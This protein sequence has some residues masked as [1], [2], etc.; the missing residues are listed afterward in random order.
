MW[1]GSFLRVEGWGYEGSAKQCCKNSNSSLL[2]RGGV[3]K[4]LYEMQE[5]PRLGGLGKEKCCYSYNFFGFTQY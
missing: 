3:A 5:C 1:G 2:M 4:V